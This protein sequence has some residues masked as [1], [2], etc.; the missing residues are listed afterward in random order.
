MLRFVG[1]AGREM[2]QRLLDDQA[3][4]EAEIGEALIFEVGVLPDESNRVVGG[5]T[6]TWKPPAAAVESDLV[7]A[8]WLRATANKLVN[9]LRPRLA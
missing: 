9:A 8:E 4:L 7:Q 2:L 1:E 3:A 5:I 6:L